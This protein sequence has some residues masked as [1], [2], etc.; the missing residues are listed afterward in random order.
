MEE[1]LKILITVLISSGLGT[2]IVE[3]MFEH[4]L[5][6]KLSRFNTLYTDKINVIKELYKLLIKAEK[7]LDLFLSQ[8]EPKNIEENRMFKDQTVLVLNSFRDYF[9]ENEI[10]FDS[11]IVSIV[12]EINKNFQEAKIT[13]LKTTI[14]E[15]DR[16]S[17]AWEKIIEKKIQLRELLVDNEIPKLK[18][19]LKREFQQEYQLLEK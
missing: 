18:E 13:Q 19:N 9:E 5:N 6:K 11:C 15:A 10:L 3:K 8:R 17:K 14:M 16:G 4:R 2:F 7:A 1:T 12:E